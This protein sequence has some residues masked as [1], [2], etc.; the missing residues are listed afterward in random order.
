MD[1]SNP[2][3]SSKIMK[4]QLKKLLMLWLLAAALTSGS[5]GAGSAAELTKLY[6]GYGGV[7]GYQL[8]VWVNKEAEIG[9]KMASTSNRC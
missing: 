6:V 2:F 4:V 8:P 3:R 1:R 7:A 5:V 9:K